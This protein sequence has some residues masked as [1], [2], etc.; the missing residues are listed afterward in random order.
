M[1]S[2]LPRPSVVT[3]HCRKRAPNICKVISGSNGL[4][5]HKTVAAMLSPSAASLSHSSWL[6]SLNLLTYF[7]T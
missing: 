1:K 5:R 6:E 3:N 7:A 4:Y 2:R